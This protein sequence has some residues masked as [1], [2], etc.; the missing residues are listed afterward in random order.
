[1]GAE[2]NETARQTSQRGTGSR[3]TPLPGTHQPSNLSAGWAGGGCIQQESF[4]QFSSA[5]V[6]SE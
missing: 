1:M 5:W 6:N 4:A 2:I 3:E